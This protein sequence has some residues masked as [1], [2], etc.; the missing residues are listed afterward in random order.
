MHGRMYAIKISTNEVTK[1]KTFLQVGRDKRLESSDDQKLL[2]KTCY[3][4]KRA[5]VCN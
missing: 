3:E 4:S 2:Q 5:G 1:A